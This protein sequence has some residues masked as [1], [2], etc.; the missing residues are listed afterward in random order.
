MKLYKRMKG[1]CGNGKLV[2]IKKENILE[3]KIEYKA[4]FP[5]TSIEVFTF[6]SGFLDRNYRGRSL[7]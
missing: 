3:L 7:A 1:L 4:V 2:L 6:S 5:L